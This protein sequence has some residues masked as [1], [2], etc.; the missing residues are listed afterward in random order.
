VRDDAVV[1]LKREK[2]HRHRQKVG[3]ERAEHHFAKGPAEA[4]E[5]APE[6]MRLG[7][8]RT[9]NARKL[10]KGDFGADGLAA[11]EGGE[12]GQRHGGAVIGA[13]AVI[14]H[15]PR[16]AL[17]KHEDGLSV[18]HARQ[19]G[20]GVGL[21]GHV[22]LHL[23]QKP[24]FLQGLGKGDRRGGVGEASKGFGDVAGRDA[25]TQHPGIDRRQRR[26]TL[27]AVMGGGGIAHRRRRGVA[28][29]HR[30]KTAARRGGHPGGATGPPHIRL[31]S[32][33]SPR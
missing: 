6:P 32:A 10:A 20:P 24:G 1:D 16:I 11:E 29:R 27:V 13:C 30:A 28:V 23:A 19:C 22:V 12:I 2:R 26:K 25:L 18:G 3:H 31:P 7:A 21:T 9:V 14:D 5:L 8:L 17:F 15:Q 4:G 33:S